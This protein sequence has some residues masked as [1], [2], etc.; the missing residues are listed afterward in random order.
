MKLKRVDQLKTYD[1]TGFKDTFITEKHLFPS[2]KSGF[3]IFKIEE[4][5]K[6]LSFPLPLHRTEYFDILFMK[7]GSCAK[8]CGLQKY[9]INA[10]EIYFKAANQITSGDVFTEDVSGFFCFFETDFISSNLGLK[11]A[12]DSFPFF[13]YGHYPIIALS[14]QEKIKFDSIFNNLHDIFINDSSSKHKLLASW[15][16]VL[17]QEASRVYHD[18]LPDTIL[19]SKIRNEILVS[20]YKDLIA[21]YCLSIRAVN[22]YADRLFVTPNYLNRVVKLIT[23]KTALSLINDMLLLEAKVHLT[24]TTLSVSEIAF[25]LNFSDTS[26]FNRFFKKHSGFTP[27][28]FR[29]KA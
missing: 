5:A 8:N 26:H 23:G 21:Q 10:G 1:Y 7:N 29:K 17:L 16:N 28:S 14:I 13:K 2:D 3:R 25:K 20:K 6:H 4:V 19:N 11:V 24:Q 27:V 18:L 15:L 22:E 9:T 12:I